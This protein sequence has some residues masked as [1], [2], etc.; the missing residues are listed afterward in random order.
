ES[1]LLRQ[2]THA[3]GIE[4]NDVRQGFGFDEG[5]AFG[6]EL[7]GDGFAVAL[8]HLAPVS[9]DKNTRHVSLRIAGK[10]REKRGVGKRFDRFDRF[11]G[12]NLDRTC[13]IYVSGAR[14]IAPRV[15]EAAETRGAMLRAPANQATTDFPKR[16][17][18]AFKLMPSKWSR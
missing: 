10:I 15:V 7:R 11:P 2:I 13:L 16:R 12:L 18:H 1:L 9:F 5:I 4:Q 6:D 17:A 8:V 3:A 14:S